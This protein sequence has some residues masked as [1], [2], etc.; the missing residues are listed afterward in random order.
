MNSKK[1]AVLME[2]HSTRANTPNQIECQGVYKLCR[3]CEDHKKVRWCHARET[4][5]H[6][7]NV[8][9][10]FSIPLKLQSPHLLAYETFDLH[11][12]IDKLLNRCSN[13]TAIIFWKNHGYYFLWSSCFYSWTKYLKFTIFLSSFIALIRW[14][15]LS[16][17]FKRD[18]KIWHSF[19]STLP[20]YDLPCPNYFQRR[21]LVH[22]NEIQFQRLYR[23]RPALALLL[24]C[25][26]WMCKVRSWKMIL[27]ESKQSSI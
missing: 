19:A 13:S 27:I 12:H 17:Y 3:R 2:L 15:L 26:T 18:Y 5:G 10:M 23:Q 20:K 25:I 7:Y 9:S 8:C 24:V 6:P 21:N 14:T 11:F 22:C 16:N 1:N 4:W